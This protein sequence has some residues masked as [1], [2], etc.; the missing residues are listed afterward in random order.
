MGSIVS[1]TRLRAR[2]A[3]A[4][5]DPIRFSYPQS[6]IDTYMSE[7]AHV[8]RVRNIYMDVTFHDYYDE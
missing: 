2:L 3:L 5:D 6:R 7:N 1:G 8:A 4:T